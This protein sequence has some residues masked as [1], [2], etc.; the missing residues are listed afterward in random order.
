MDMPGYETYDKINKYTVKPVKM[1]QNQRR[2]PRS[3]VNMVDVYRGEPP[4]KPEPIGDTDNDFDDNIDTDSGI[5]E[6]MALNLA[7]DKEH[8]D[9]CAFMAKKFVRR[10]PAGGAPP[11]RGA[12]GQFQPIAA[13]FWPAGV[14]ARPP[15]RDRKAAGAEAT[16][17]TTALTTTTKTHNRYRAL[18]VTD[19]WEIDAF[20]NPPDIPSSPGS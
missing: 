5:V 3:G 13:R 1:M 12:G 14:A 11:P 6:I 15:P 16:T 2:R 19:L 9:I 7:P 18:T 17:T 4:Q 10:G 8:K 20:A